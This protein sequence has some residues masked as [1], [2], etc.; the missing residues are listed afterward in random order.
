MKGITTTVQ[1]VKTGK[2]KEYS[3]Y[4]IPIP[5]AIVELSGLKKGDTF[6]WTIVND[7]II[8]ER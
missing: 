3:K 7:K 6:R 1:E 8:L 2:D 4:T 5:N